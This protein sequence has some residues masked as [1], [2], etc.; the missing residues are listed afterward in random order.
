MPDD[1]AATTGMWA[2]SGNKKTDFL[3]NGVNGDDRR[4]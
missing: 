1:E 2:V 3:T 4:C